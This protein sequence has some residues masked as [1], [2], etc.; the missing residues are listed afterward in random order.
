[1]LEWLFGGDGNNGKN[2]KLQGSV[3]EVSRLFEK[4]KDDEFEGTRLSKALVLLAEARKE[5]DSSLDE[6]I[7]KAGDLIAEALEH[8]QE[9]IRKRELRLQE[10]QREGK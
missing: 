8:M 9:R 10:I 2:K 3:L 6:V 4:S 5:C 7:Q 1:M